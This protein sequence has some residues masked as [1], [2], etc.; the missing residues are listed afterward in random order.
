MGKCMTLLRNTYYDEVLIKAYRDAAY[1]A[2]QDDEEKIRINRE[3]YDGAQ[4]VALTARQKEYL[5]G[6]ADDIEDQALCNILKR[7]VSIPLERLGIESISGVDKASAKF[8]ETVSVWWKANLM[9]SW[10]YDLME[11]AMRDKASCVIIGWDGDMPSFTIND[12]YSGSGNG[13]RLHYSD[14]DGKLLF[15]SKRY[16]PYDD[17]KLINTGKPRLTLYLPDMIIRFEQ[18]TADATGWRLLDPA[19]IDENKGK[20]TSEMTPNPQPW[21]DADGNPMGVPVI[22]FWNPGGS[23]LDDV[24]IP[25]KSLNKA[26]TDMLSA[27]DLQGFPFL[28]LIGMEQGKDGKYPPIEVGPGKGLAVPQGGD[29]KRVAGVD[30]APMF[31]TGAKGWLELISIIKGWP[32]Y[33]LMN[34]QPPSG[35]ALK[36]MESSLVKQCVRKQEG[37]GDSWREAFAM[38]AKLHRLYKHEELKGDIKLIWLKPETDDPESEWNAKKIKWEAAMVPVTQRWREAGYTEA[39]ISTMLKE[40]A[41][42]ASDSA[43]ETVRNAMLIQKSASAV[44]GGLGDGQTASAMV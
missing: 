22:T 4:G 24:L 3:F 15:A 26:L 42:Q 36:V 1:A 19:E 20:N 14:N 27:Q 8:G 16:M 29:V 5:G 30:I 32:L 39:T 31:E 12:L 37:F 9:S 34:G 21:K 28:A 7:V 25:Q 44:D 6:I 2:I 43:M 13:I 23:E 33:L 11:H 40:S 18:S 17:Q 10:Q 35:V 41:M 38:G